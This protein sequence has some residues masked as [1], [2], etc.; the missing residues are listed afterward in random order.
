MK[1]TVLVKIL[2]RSYV[3]TS[4]NEK[5][6]KRGNRVKH[7]V[8]VCPCTSTP[9]PNCI[10][11]RFLWVKPIGNSNSKIATRLKKGVARHCRDN[12]FMGVQM[13]PHMLGQNGIKGIS[14]N[15]GNPRFFLEQVQDF[16][17]GGHPAVNAGAGRT[18]H[19][20][21][22]FAMRQRLQCSSLT[23]VMPSIS[24]LAK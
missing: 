17:V 1:L 23:I 19:Y 15:K 14:F 2:Q 16:L 21:F 13:L 20:S 8:V 7:L 11:I 18:D 9:W 10:D 24:R 12:R 3:K 22:K 6:A 5:I 4:A